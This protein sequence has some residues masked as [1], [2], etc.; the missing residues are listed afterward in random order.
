ME[1]ILKESINGVGERGERKNVKPG[2]ARNYLLPSGLAFLA[3]QP[4]AKKLETEFLAKKEKEEQA[5]NQSELAE[6]IQNLQLDFTLKAE[7]GKK[8]YAGISAKKI[9]EELEKKYQFQP[10]KID[11]KSALKKEG[12]HEVKIVVGGK[13]FDVKVKIATK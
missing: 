7:K 11:L 3:G 2:F 8:T 10:E 9:A 12:E 5:E 6:A 1:V 4:E 13:Q